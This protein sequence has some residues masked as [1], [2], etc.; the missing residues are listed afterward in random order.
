MSKQRFAVLLTVLVLTLTGV[1]FASAAGMEI[2]PAPNDVP[3]GAMS[4]GNL[5]KGT[6]LDPNI[7]AALIGV[8][9]LLVGSF[10][11]IGGTYFLRFLD[12][13]REDRREEAFMVRERKEKEF[14]I[15]QEIYKNFLTELGLMEGFLLH[16]AE[17]SSM[18]DIESF[19]AEWTK[20]EIKMN[21]VCSTKIRTDLDEV[22][23]ELINIA[24]KRFEG[25]KADLNHEY[26]A[27]RG[28]LLDAIREDID[29]FHTN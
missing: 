25:G 23:E 18:K 13:K 28:E 10:L 9:G 29:L 4:Y 19:N 16:K 3:P 22:Q 27:K 11:T 5:A 6:G 26:L 8:L 1:H 7:V 12:V 15:K 24:K 20:M 2:I 14:Q 21:L 17:N